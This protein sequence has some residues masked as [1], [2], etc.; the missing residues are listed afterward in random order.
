MR[1]NL[2]KRIDGRNRTASTEMRVTENRKG[3]TNKASREDR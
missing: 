3:S 1:P 2:T